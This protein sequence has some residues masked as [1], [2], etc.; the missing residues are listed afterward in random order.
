MS[1]KN[2]LSWNIK[3]TKN[4]D[5]D[6]PPNRLSRYTYTCLYLLLSVGANARQPLP[7]PLIGGSSDVIQSQ[8]QCVKFAIS[9]GAHCRNRTY[10]PTGG[11]LPKNLKICFSFID[12]CTTSCIFNFSIFLISDPLD[13]GLSGHNVLGHSPGAGQGV[14]ESDVTSVEHS[15]ENK[16]SHCDR[17]L[18]CVAKY[19][20]RVKLKS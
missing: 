15:K 5:A 9:P 11:I 10:V 3:G 1:L 14:R 20:R 13:N 19:H 7:F 2:T 8:Q 6:F 16:R 12:T 17:G 18:Y 4:S